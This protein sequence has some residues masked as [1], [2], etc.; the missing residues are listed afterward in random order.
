MILELEVNLL[1]RCVITCS[2]I[3][4]ATVTAHATYAVV[5][6]V[7]GVLQVARHMAHASNT[8]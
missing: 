4:L 2:N 8:L 5:R 6:F 7:K 1:G 3:C